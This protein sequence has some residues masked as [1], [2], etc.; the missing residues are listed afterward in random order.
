M[1]W[2]CWENK[3][4]AGRLDVTGTTAQFISLACYGNALLRGIP[5]ADF[6]PGNSTFQFCDSVNFVEVSK[7]FFGKTKEVL[8]ASNPVAW[9]E[10]LKHKTIHGLKLSWKPG[11]DPNLAGRMAAAFVGGG[12]T[13]ELEAVGKNDYSQ[14]WLSRW[15]VGNQNAPDRKIWRVTYGRVGETKTSGLGETDLNRIEEELRASLQNI[16]E[17]ALRINCGGFAEY[18]LRALDT[19]ENKSNPSKLYHRDLA[20]DGLLSPQAARILEACQ[21]A[22]VFGGMGSWNDMVFEGEEQQRYDSVSERLF[23]SLHAAIPS[24]TNNSF[25]IRGMAV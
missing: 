8:V 25:E 11:N 10:Y 15:E 21:H 12:G 19:L 24:A 4:T 3:S 9:F 14:L 18:F 13:W 2:T 23:K 6:S 20:P 7:N 22:W 5:I 1:S 17:F 16:H